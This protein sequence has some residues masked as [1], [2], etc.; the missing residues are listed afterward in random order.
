MTLLYGLPPII[1]DRAEV[2]ILGSFPSEASLAARQYY[3]HPRNQ[4]WKILAAIIH[5]PLCEMDY[6]ARQVAVKAAGIAIWD[7][8]AC[9][10]RV[11]S[12]DAAIRNGVPN[13]FAALKNSVLVGRHDLPRV[14]FNGRTAG[15]FSPHLT[16]LGFTTQILPSTS[17]AHA[18]LPYAE[19]L[20]IWRRALAL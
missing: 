4:F 9:C 6:A 2:L 13:D 1:D 5:Q 16:A 19:K 17:P 20:A 7:V 12:L 15:R 3:A 18:G 8:Y 10:E 11:G 14:F